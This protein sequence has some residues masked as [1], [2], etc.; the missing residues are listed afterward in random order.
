MIVET[1]FQQWGLAFIGEFKDNS[2]NGYQWILTAIDYFTIWV[3]IVPTKKATEEVV[4]NVLE[5]RI[6]TRFGA[7]AKITTNNDKDFISFVLA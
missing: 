2:S 7:P 1:P 6:I 4:M 3:E 5:K